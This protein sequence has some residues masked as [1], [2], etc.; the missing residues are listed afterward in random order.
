R[1]S[2]RHRHLDL[3]DRSFEPVEMPRLVAQ[4]SGADEKHLIHRIAKLQPAILD[5]HAGLP[6]RHEAPVDISRAA[7]RGAA[8][9]FLN[10][11]AP[12]CHG[13]RMRATQVMLTRC[14]RIEMAFLKACERAEPDWAARIRGP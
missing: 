2:H 12:L 11:H 14:R 4:L 5:M 3:A 1:T 8:G 9:P 6:V 10:R 7:G 13:P